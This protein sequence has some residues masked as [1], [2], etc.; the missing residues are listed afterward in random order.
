[1]SFPRFY[2]MLPSFFYFTGFYQ[3]LISFI[4]LYWMIPFFLGFTGFLPSFTKF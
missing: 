2:R 3:V 4:E 1:M